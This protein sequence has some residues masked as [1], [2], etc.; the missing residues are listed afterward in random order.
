VLI[1]VDEA[2]RATGGYAYSV[3]I[4]DMMVLNPHFRVLALTATPGSTRDA[5][6]VVVDN[7][8]ISHIEI[9]NEQ[10]LDLRQYVHKKVRVRSSIHRRTELEHDLSQKLTQHLVTLP[11]NLTEIA[12]TIVKLMEVSHIILLLST[13]NIDCTCCFRDFT[14]PSVT[15]YPEQSCAP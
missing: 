14:P 12:D 5:V 1:V 13:T 9:R 3:A 10:S 4:R 7:M 6:Q 2:H 15:S 8:H 11:Q